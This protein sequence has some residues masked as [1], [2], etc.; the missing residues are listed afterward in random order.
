MAEY[1]TISQGLHSLFT[2]VH[3]GLGKWCTTLLFLLTSYIIIIYFIWFFLPDLLIHLFCIVVQ[4]RSMA[5]YIYIYPYFDWITNAHYAGVK[6]IN[7]LNLEI[8]EIEVKNTSHDLSYV[9]A[10]MFITAGWSWQTWSWCRPPK[11]NVPVYYLHHHEYNNRTI[12]HKFVDFNAKF[13]QNLPLTFLHSA[14]HHSPQLEELK[15][16]T[17]PHLR[18]WC[19]VATQNAALTWYKEQMIIV[20][21][22]L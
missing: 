10:C 12:Y 22:V 15:K 1:G 8:W 13:H 7:G 17:R 5:I 2:C 21:P 4:S 18:W 9:S 11:S 14:R 20:I 19:I 3:V 16:Q 6:S